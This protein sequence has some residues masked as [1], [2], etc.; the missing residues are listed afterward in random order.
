MT[1]AQLIFLFFIIASVY[2]SASFFLATYGGRVL[3]P[4]NIT[5]DNMTSLYLA[6]AF[7]VI[8]HGI[9]NFLDTLG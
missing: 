2:C 4:R 1:G 9:K 7:G 3:P 6:I 8:A 5:R